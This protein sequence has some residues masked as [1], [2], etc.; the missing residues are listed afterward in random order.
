MN[1][2]YVIVLILL[3]AI[4]VWMFIQ[5]LSG[6][7]AAKIPMIGISLVIVG[8]SVGHIMKSPNPA[9]AQ[10]KKQMVWYQ[11]VQGE[12]VGLR[13]ARSFPGA[14]VMIIQPYDFSLG[15]GA[16]PLQAGL[17]KSIEAALLKSGL[18]VDV[19]TLSPP[20]ELQEMLDQARNEGMPAPKLDFASI[21]SMFG[22]QI[23][24]LQPFLNEFNGQFDVVISTL[25]IG[26]NQD[27]MALPA[28]GQSPPLV[29][30]NCWMENVGS[31][32]ARTS[33]A[34]IV[35]PR[36]DLKPE[37]YSRTLDGSIDEDF[38]TRFEYLTDLNRGSAAAL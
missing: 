10:V 29:L 6:S 18:E 4:L 31:I 33:V 15:S 30:V 7:T 37:D 17:V 27:I 32:F 20:N 19:R 3:G 28:K 13:V 9:R 1:I 5:H 24:G 23:N 22:P 11:K 21:E 35:R 36:R 14:R 12:Y 38:T 2:L 16:S 25:F 34:A 26:L 8:L